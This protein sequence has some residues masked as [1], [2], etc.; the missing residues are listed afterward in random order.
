MVARR[1]KGA[2]TEH[3]EPGNGKI[4]MS[5]SDYVVYRVQARPESYRERIRRLEEER[6]RAEEELRRAEEER[7]KKEEERRR[8]R[9]EQIEAANEALRCAAELAESLREGDRARRQEKP[10]SGE[11]RS[12]AAGGKAKETILKETI[13]RIRE[14]IEEAPSD[15]K[16]RHGEKIA[17][18]NS[19][20]RS[21]EGSGYDAYYASSV[22]WALSHLQNLVAHYHENLRRAEGPSPEEQDQL[23]RLSA[24]LLAIIADPV[25]PDIEREAQELR[26]RQQSLICLE[27]G[28]A[29]RLGIEALQ[30]DY[31]RLAEAHEYLILKDE[32]R[33]YVGQCVQELL[34]EMGYEVIPL[35]PQLPSNPALAEK[36]F[37]TPDGEAVRVAMGLEQD[38]HMELL[39]VTDEGGEGGSSNEEMIEKGHRFCED[40]RLL[41]Q[42][43]R[44]RDIEA[45]SR[46]TIGPEG[47]VFKTFPLP[48]TIELRRSR[49]RG[50]RRT[51]GRGEST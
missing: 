44:E 23:N 17:D 47:L 33:R 42:G 9:A 22:H 3:F 19:L 6:R 43:L 34:E 36:Y 50:R 49:E 35:E 5:T 31:N 41:L 21:V 51:L 13:N 15:F 40:Y 32:E 12:G 8:I 10:T 20:I 14:V 2:R 45:V 25:T 48:A 4:G 26:A 27:D 1:A 30:R 18:I 37:L 7:K 16:E 38:L 28:A 39:R 29:R 24:G 46:L 11:E